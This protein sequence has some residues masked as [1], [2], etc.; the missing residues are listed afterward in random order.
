LGLFSQ[1]GETDDATVW[2]GTL[3]VSGKY[4]IVVGGTRGNAA[5]KLKITIY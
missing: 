1:A 4:L 2:Q 3:P 5:Y